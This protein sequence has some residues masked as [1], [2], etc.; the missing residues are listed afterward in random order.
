MNYN[1]GI[2]IDGEFIPFDELAEFVDAESLPQFIKPIGGFCFPA[3]SFLRMPLDD[4]PFYIKGWLPKQGRLEFYGQAKVGK[5]FLAAHLANCVGSGTPF[6]GRDVE[7]GRVL[8]LQFEVG[9]EILQ[10]RM[11]ATGNGFDDVYVGVTF[12]M[13]LDTPTGQEML[14]NA[15]EAIEPAV[16]ILDPLYKAISGDENE[17]KDVR[18]I[19]DFLDS[20]IEQYHVSFVV[21]HHGGK[22]QSKGGRGA[23]VLEDWFDTVIEIKKMNNDED[24]HLIVRL[25]EMMMRHDVPGDPTTVEMDDSGRYVMSSAPENVYS[26]ML[27]RILDP[28]APLEWG[29]SF[30]EDIAGNKAIYENLAT[31][32]DQNIIEKVGRGVYRRKVAPEEE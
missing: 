32:T 12:G 20:L 6:L 30:L 16:V 26:K 18:D 9:A 29:F 13:K 8:F 25:K 11:I 17:T 10:Q 23:S 14:R 3:N 2:Y 7:Q 5:T 31:L 28:L 19:L 27:K 15:I 4:I 21:F 22:D 1:N 24:R